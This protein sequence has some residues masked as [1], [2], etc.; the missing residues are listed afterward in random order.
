MEMETQT[1][2]KYFKK[3]I[4]KHSSCHR[5][6]FSRTSRTNRTTK[7]III[8]IIIIIII[9]GGRLKTKLFQLRMNN[10]SRAPCYSRPRGNGSQSHEKNVAKSMKSKTLASPK[11]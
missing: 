6:K 8:I 9:M 5:R 10:T 2:N 4:S 1:N 3:T 11:E 7:L